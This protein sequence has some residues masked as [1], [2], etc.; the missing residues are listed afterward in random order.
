MIRR[1]PRSTQPTTLFPYTTL[2]RSQQGAWQSALVDA[3]ARNGWGGRL[4]ERLVAAETAN[5]GYCDVSLAG[6]NLWQG[7]DRG[8]APYRVSSSGDFGFDFY[9]AKGSD[10]LSA[11]INSLLGEA[12]SDPFEQTWLTMMG[13]SIDNQRVLSSALQSSTLR[14][15]FPNTGLGRQL[16]MAARL[17][18][19]RGALGVPRQ[20]FFASIGGFDTHGDDQLQRQNELLGE[21]GNAVAAFHAATVELGVAQQVTLFTASDFGRTFA[22]N[23]EGSDHGWGAHHWVVGGAVQGGRVVGRFPELVIGGPDDAG[24]QGNWV[25]GLSI[26]QIGAELGRWFGADEALLDDVFPRLRQFDR[27]IGLMGA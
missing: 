14:T 4:L 12:R 1:P 6:G 27:R 24:G 8:L 18:A 15:S 17:I 7:G 11:A 3:P 25:P 9:D 23:G 26:D 20:C 13:R 21:I 19:A 10:P 5:R 22:S 2:F 16:Q